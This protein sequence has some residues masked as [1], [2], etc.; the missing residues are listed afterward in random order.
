MTTGRTWSYA[1]APGDSVTDSWPL[2]NF[3]D[4]AYHL[5]VHGPNGYY[6]EFRGDASDPRFDIMLAPDDA[7]NLIFI[8]ANLDPKQQVTVRAE[9]PGCNTTASEEDVQH[10]KPM[11]LAFPV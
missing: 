5:R 1:V 10:G 7:G 8:L 11:Q 6:R 2:Q 3:A 9:I 4:S